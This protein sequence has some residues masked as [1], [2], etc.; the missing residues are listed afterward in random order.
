MFCALIGHYNRDKKVLSFPIMHRGF[1]I[2]A[3][4]VEFYQLWENMR[5]VEGTCECGDEHSGFIKCG[6][7]LH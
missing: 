2:V 6:V 1:T 7:F 3:F 5:Q 4:L